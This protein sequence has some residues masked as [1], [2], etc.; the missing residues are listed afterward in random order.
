[1][2]VV[3]L[4]MTHR[5]VLLLLDAAHD[6]FV[7]RRSRTIGALSAAHRRRLLASS[8]G[9]L[10]AKSLHVSGEVF[11]AMQARGYRG[12][13]HLLDDFVMRRADWLARASFAAA[14]AIA[15]WIGR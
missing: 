8:A 13:V 1:V 12:E 4:G 7:A 9:S 5:Y 2:L 15:V 11:L 10:L 6:M 3:V 14:A